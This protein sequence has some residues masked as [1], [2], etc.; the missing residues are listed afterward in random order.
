MAAGDLFEIVSTQMPEDAPGSLE[1]EQYADIVAFVLRLNGFEP[2][3]G[4]LPADADALGTI[5]LAPLG[6]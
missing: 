4:E 5:S 1:L 6:N 3:S 2:G